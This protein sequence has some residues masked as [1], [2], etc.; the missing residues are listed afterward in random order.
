[1]A[2]ANQRKMESIPI[3]IAIWIPMKPII[4][5]AALGFTYTNPLDRP[6]PKLWRGKWRVDSQRLTGNGGFNRQRWLS[7][8]IG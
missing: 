7:P 8:A 3:S 4:I 1:M 5:D 2:T 6:A